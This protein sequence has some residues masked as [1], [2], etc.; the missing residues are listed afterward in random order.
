LNGPQ[1]QLLPFTSQLIHT[2]AI[3]GWFYSHFGKPADFLAIRGK[4]T[5]SAWRAAV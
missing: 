3:P 4:T 1:E 2:E 5:W